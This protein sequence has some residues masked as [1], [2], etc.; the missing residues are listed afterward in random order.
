MDQEI[1]FKKRPPRQNE[2]IIFKRDSQS[3]KC[4]QPLKEKN[5]K[6]TT[7][8]QSKEKSDQKT[9]DQK[10]SD[11]KLIS[12]LLSQNKIV[13]H[14]FCL[15]VKRH[16]EI[17][18]DLSGLTEQKLNKLYQLYNQE[19]FLQGLTCSADQHLRFELS[20]RMTS[21]AGVCEYERRKKVD[22]YLIKMAFQLIRTL[23][24]DHQT[25]YRVN[26]LDCRTHLEVFLNI[27]E[28]ELVHLWF[29]LRRDHHE[30]HGKQF[31]LM[32]KKLFGHTDFRHNLKTDINVFGVDQREIK[33]FQFVSFQIQD[34]QVKSGRVM[35]FN[36]KTVGVRIFGEKG[37]W[38]I[39]YSQIKKV[40][41][42]PSADD[43]M[44]ER[45]ML[46]Q[47]K[48][49]DDF[50]LNQKVQFESKD[51]LLPGVIIKLNPKRAKVKLND[52]GLMYDVPY[53]ILVPS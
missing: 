4:D 35:K 38:R 3:G 5:D 47:L 48:T 37:E 6:L 2:V 12:D 31:Q 23:F 15:Q 30:Q 11:Q 53:Q 1:I 39:P 8:T 21:T 51:G 33:H 49:K 40:E 20:N 36:L 52:N 16:L 19:Y 14:Q 10:T 27:F 28:H 29:Q 45:T 25:I 24:S 42:Q 9:S 18:D 44:A 32:V 41:Y 50:F 26:G 7:N 34:N 13:R 43:L 17:A 22:Y 46:N